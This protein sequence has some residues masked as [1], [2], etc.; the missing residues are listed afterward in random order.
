MITEKRCLNNSIIILKIFF[1][2]LSITSLYIGN[3]CFPFS[4]SSSNKVAN[5]QKIY[6]IDFYLLHV[7]SLKHFG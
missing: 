3:L 1:K 4:N 6:G 5:E 2:I 7:I